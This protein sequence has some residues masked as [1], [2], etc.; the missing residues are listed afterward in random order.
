MRSDDRAYSHGASKN[1]AITKGS[2]SMGRPEYVTNTRA[3]AAGA[4]ASAT[5]TGANG[6]AAASLD[7]NKMAQA[8][9]QKPTVSHMLGELTWLLS[10][11]ASHKH[12]AIGDLEWLVMPAILLEQFRVF[13][14]DPSTG[15]REEKG[16]EG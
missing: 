4:Q 2:V 10:Q 8:N 7:E 9:A 11:S 15:K 16:I 5:A 14:I 1:K 3:E 13:H 6:A 12:F